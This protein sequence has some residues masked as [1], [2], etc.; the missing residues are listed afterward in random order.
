MG[1]VGVG[2]VHT[3]TQFKEGTNSSASTQEMDIFGVAT[4]LAVE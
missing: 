4:I 2:Y 1:N 3:E